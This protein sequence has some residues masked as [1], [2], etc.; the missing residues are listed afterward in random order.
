VVF[1]HICPEC[2]IDALC[3]EKNVYQT[4]LFFESLVL[5]NCDDAVQKSFTIFILAV[6]I[7]AWC[8][9]ERNQT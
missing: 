7:D 5:A 4:A 2:L 9:G 6:D 8:A 1:Y 3:V